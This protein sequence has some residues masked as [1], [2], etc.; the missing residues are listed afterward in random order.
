MSFSGKMTLSEKIKYFFAALSCFPFLIRE[1]FSPPKTTDEKGLFAETFI[2][3]VFKY[4]LN[5]NYIQKRNVLLFLNDD[6]TEIDLLIISKFG[7][8]I[9][10]TKHRKGSIYGKENDTKWT[11][12]FSKKVTYPFQNPLKQNYKHL[13][14]IEE[15][16]GI[17]S[18]HIHSVIVFFE[19][20]KLPEIKNVGKALN[21]IDYIQSFKDIVFND[22]ELTG[23]IDR[24]E[25]HQKKYIPENIQAH[26]NSV[27]KIIEEKTTKKET[28]IIETINIETSIIPECPLCGSPM[29]LRKTKLPFWGCSQFGKK[30]CRGKR[31]CETLEPITMQKTSK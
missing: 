22:E 8:F 29:E 31:D 19:S 20:K 21:M 10:E 4:L 2:N 9:V 11:Q 28:K 25:N 24:I 18:N 23:I 30:L 17:S 5:G 1:K 13:K 27:Q 15:I 26:I 12:Y 6:T 7:I 14:F 16:T 3:R